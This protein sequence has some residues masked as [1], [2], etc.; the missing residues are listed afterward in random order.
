[1]TKGTKNYMFT[2]GKL[3]K[4]WRTGKTPHSLKVYTFEEDTKLCVVATLEEYLK[5]RKCWR[6]KDI[7]QWS[8]QKYLDGIRT[9]FLKDT[10]H[11]EPQHQKLA[12]RE[13]L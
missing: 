5:R 3:H 13:F 11:V 12:W 7:I 8:V 1:M 2:F 10:L 9:S 4:A 6:G